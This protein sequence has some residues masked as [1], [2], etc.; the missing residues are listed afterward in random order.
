MNM[1]METH[2]DMDKDMEM[3]MDMETDRLKYWY[4]FYLIAEKEVFG[5]TIFSP[6]SDLK[7]LSSEM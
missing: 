7:V 5:Q 1:N 2:M 6:I 3:D 4:N